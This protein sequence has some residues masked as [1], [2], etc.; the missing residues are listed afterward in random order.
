[1]TVTIDPLHK[2]GVYAYQGWTFDDGCSSRVP[3]DH[4]SVDF[5]PFAPVLTAQEP[6]FP[7]LLL[8]AH[9]RPPEY[10]RPRRGPRGFDSGLRSRRIDLGNVAL[11][12][13]PKFMPL[14]VTRV[15]I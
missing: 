4:V 12:W 3:W 15:Y 10:P 13:G 5:D 9:R 6:I 14:I 1:M 7:N 11:V 8:C 2:L